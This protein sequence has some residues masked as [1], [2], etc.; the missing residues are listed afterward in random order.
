VPTLSHVWPQLMEIGLVPLR[1][2]HE[3][4]R[5]RSALQRLD[6]LIPSP[7]TSGYFE[8]FELVLKEARAHWFPTASVLQCLDEW[9]SQV[10]GNM[11]SVDA[12]VGFLETRPVREQVWPGL[13]WI[14]RIVVTVQVVRAAAGAEKAQQSDDDGSVRHR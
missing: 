12:L 5:R 9:L 1:E 14:R 11:H 8:D 13:D 2:P 7:R 4:E 3:P 10:Q 6:S